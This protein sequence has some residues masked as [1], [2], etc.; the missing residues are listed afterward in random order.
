MLPDVNLLVCGFASHVVELSTDG[1]MLRNFN[2]ERT[3]KRDSRSFSGPNNG[4]LVI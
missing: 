1:R 4:D 2:C 3:S